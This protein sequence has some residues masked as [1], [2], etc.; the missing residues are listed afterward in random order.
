MSQIGNQL[1]SQTLDTVV[2]TTF[3]TVG[4]RVFPDLSAEKGLLEFIAIVDSWRATHAQ[5]FG[6]PLP[7]AG[8]GFSVSTSSTDSPVDLVAAVDNQVVRINAISTTN[9]G[10]GAPVG[11]EIHLGDTLLI[12][13]ASTPSST[14]AV[15]LNVPIYVSKGQTL[16]LTATSGT[17]SDL[18]AKASGVNSCS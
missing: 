13:G 6:A 18:T 14:E 2:S 15:A 9:A 8:V 3:N 12:S 11:F 17:A 4:G 7:N 16:T 1:K 10:G 5:A